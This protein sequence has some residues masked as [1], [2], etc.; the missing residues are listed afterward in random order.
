LTV[1][2]SRIDASDL[3][4]S[5]QRFMPVADAFQAHLESAG[6]IGP[7]DAERTPPRLEPPR[8]NPRPNPFDNPKPLA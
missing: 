4:D 1:P 8:N 5:C 6:A 3:V 2:F 7:Q